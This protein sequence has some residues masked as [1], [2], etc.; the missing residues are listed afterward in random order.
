MLFR[1]THLALLTHGFKR[2]GFDWD[3]LPKYPVGQEQ[4]KVLLEKDLHTPSFWHGFDKQGFDW[5]VLPTKLAG[6]E[7][8][9]VLL[10]RE[11]LFITI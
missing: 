2:Q 10:D 7:H 1:K 11:V 6:H 9:N 5:H 8:E 3:V 4:E